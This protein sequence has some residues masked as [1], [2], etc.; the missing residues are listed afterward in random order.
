VLWDPATRDPPYSNDNVE[1]GKNFNSAWNLFFLP[2]RNFRFA[3]ASSF[4]CMSQG[5]AAVRPVN[6]NGMRREAGGGS[7]DPASL[8]KPLRTAVVTNGHDS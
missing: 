2:R 7:S 8:T 1:D 6:G 5:A 3:G 4:S